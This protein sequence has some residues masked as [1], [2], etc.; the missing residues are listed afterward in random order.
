M[1]ETTRGSATPFTGRSG[2]L[3]WLAV[4]FTCRTDPRSE[5]IRARTLAG[6]FALLFAALGV[7]RD[8]PG[9][10]FLIQ[11]PFDLDWALRTVSLGWYQPD[12]TIPVTIVDIDEATHRGWRSP[13]IT[14]RGELARLL[15]VVTA[16]APS[17]VVV[18]I[19]LSGTEA[20]ADRAGQRQLRDVLEG[21]RGTAPL[22]FPK[23]IEPGTD[24]T[25]NM[26]ASPFDPVFARN[27]R[28][29][30]AH[31]SFATDSGGAVRWWTKWLAVCTESQA[32]WL[33]AIPVRVA[34]TLA[35]MQPGLAPQVEPAAAADCAARDNT[36]GQRLLIGP[37]L[38]GLARPPMARDAR[39]VPASLVLDPEIARDDAGLF[40]GRVVLIGATHTGGGDFWLT[41]S[42]VLPGVEMLANIVRYTPLE[43]GTGIGAEIAYRA[44]GLLLFAVFVVFGWYLR[45]L[46]AFFLGIA[47][48]LLIVAVAIGG[49]DY[50]RVFEALEAAIVLTVLYMFVQ[51]VLD[52]I[53]DFRRQWKDF[54]P[55]KRRFWQTLCAVCGRED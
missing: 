43:P 20:D 11:A 9:V 51:A 45:G 52:L 13:A 32:L 54:A 38:T 42:G 1:P 2:L 27:A 18:D 48:A 24:G 35:G 15:S 33:P 40:G 31:A 53:E 14:P 41:P 3:H 30:W 5:R 19:D 46:V 26:S 22:I 21:Y 6:L 50:F 8:V 36:A 12:D 47:A 7:V 23:R 29:H 34:D 16:V 17:A 49:W 10:G 25:R 55:G 4:T 37:R 28:L 39:T 44:L